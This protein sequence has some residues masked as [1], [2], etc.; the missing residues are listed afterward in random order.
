VGRGGVGG[1]GDDIGMLGHCRS[2]NVIFP[3]TETK[4]ARRA[5]AT[6]PATRVP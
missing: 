4:P 1:G 5:M 3:R 2:P 6:A